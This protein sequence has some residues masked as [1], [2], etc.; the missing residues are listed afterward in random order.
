MAEI[1]S[2]LFEAWKYHLDSQLEALATPEAIREAA[3][4]WKTAERPDKL[5]VCRIAARLCK[6]EITLTALD[7]LHKENELDM[8]VK[9]SLIQMQFL[10]DTRVLTFLFESNIAVLEHVLIH[11]KAV[12]DDIIDW[13]IEHLDN[14]HAAIIAE[15]LIPF[16]NSVVRLIQHFP[17][18]LGFSPNWSITST[19]KRVLEQCIFYGYGHKI[20]PHALLSRAG[21]L[22]RYAIDIKLESFLHQKSGSLWSHD[23]LYE[24]LQ[25]KVYVDP[26]KLAKY[27]GRYKNLEADAELYLAQQTDEYCKIYR[28]HYALW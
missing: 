25:T 12:D 9:S 24:V 5:L 27:M 11:M 19:H 7:I 6:T 22:R 28:R 2:R 8:L 26:Y 13:I 4:F 14:S 1:A 16:P 21:W 23:L 15:M 10:Y 20:S 17:M 18:A 3:Q